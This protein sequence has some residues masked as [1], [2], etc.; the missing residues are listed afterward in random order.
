MAVASPDVGERSSAVAAAKRA[1]VVAEDGRTRARVIGL[2]QAAGFQVVFQ[3]RAAAST[4]R[5]IPAEVLVQVVVLVDDGERGSLGHHVRAL[6]TQLS[7]ETL[8]VVVGS[9]DRRGAVQG[10]LGA[11]AGAFVTLDLLDEAFVPSLAA[12]LVGQLVVPSGRTRRLQALVLSAREKQ[13][14]AL[15]VMGMTNAEIAGKLY[16]AESTVKS[17]LSSAFGKLGVRSRNEAAAI[18]L[19][20][21]LGL[22]LGILAISTNG[23]GRESI[24]P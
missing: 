2:L 9:D 11:G 15:V 4:P 16:L 10:A 23:V 7:E 24:G 13:V 14:L 6:R 22:G 8:I 21:H 3:T 18:I 12:A 17:H 20:P 19:D 1:A 5:S